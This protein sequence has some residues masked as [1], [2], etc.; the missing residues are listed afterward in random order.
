[1]RLLSVFRTPLI[2]F[3][4]AEEDFGVIPEPVPA[5]QQM[6]DWFKRA[7]RKI[8]GR[9]HFGAKSFGAKKCSPLVDGMALGFTI[10]LFA[11]LN[12]RTSETG[13][14][15]EVSNPP[16]GPAAS[17]HDAAQLGPSS[18]TGRG[19]AIKF[20]NRW[21]I[22]TAP[23]VSSLFIPPMNHFD[24]RFTCLGALVDTDRY[25]NYINFPAVWHLPDF[26]DVVKAGTPLVTVIPIRRADAKA[27][28]VVRVASPREVEQVRKTE[29][30]QASRRSYYTDDV[31][32]KK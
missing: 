11:D 23:G 25:P 10:P 12:V 24:E 28:P 8:E 14:F 16:I 1:M 22:R 27:D 31:R 2:E 32:V 18:P 13:Q 4:C 30:I 3:L 21:L 29:R 7:P 17:F 9:D 20:H 6:A 5:G 26:D 19:P 15:M